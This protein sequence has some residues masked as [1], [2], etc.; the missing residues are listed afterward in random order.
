MD[1]VALAAGGAGGAVAAA[2]G[3][4][5]SACT[6]GVERVTTTTASPTDEAP[7]SR[8][9]ASG[10]FKL[11]LRVFLRITIRPFYQLDTVLR[12]HYREG[13]GYLRRLR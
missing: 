9:I 5:A 1:G 2:L 7:A 13:Y 4:S 11:V 10:V 8:Q 3:S 6:G 12:T